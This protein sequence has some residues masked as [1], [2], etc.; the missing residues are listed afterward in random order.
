MRI[1]S[2]L[3]ELTPGCSGKA[4]LL[5]DSVED[6]WHLY[7][8]IGKGDFIKTIT[9]RK[10]A[11]ESGGKSS[12]TKKKINITI[13][14]EEI[15]YDQKEGI[16]RYKGKN[17]SE[18]EFI[19]IG[20]YQS[21]EIAKG[22]TFTVFKKNWD[23]FHIERLKQATDPTVSSDL[24]AIVMEEGVA[25][26]YL[27]SAHLTT[28]Q[29]KIEQ[30]IPK[31]RKGATQHDKSLITFFQKIL[32]A[33]AK[34]INFELVKCVIVAS[35][36][37]TKDQFADYLAN[38]TSNDKYNETIQKNLNK[39]IY[40]H[41]SSGYKQAL[42]EV[43]GKQ[44]VL[45][46]IKNTKATEDVAMMEKFNEIL[47][48]DMDRIV[49]GL[50]SVQNASDK[51]AIE[52]LILTDNFLRKVSPQI[53]QSVTQ[54]MKHVKS[55]GGNVFK[56]SSQHVTG[57]KVDSFGGITAILRYAMPEL[58]D[59]EVTTIEELEEQK[60]HH[61]EDIEEDDKFA[62]NALQQMNL[63]DD[64]M[65]TNL[66]LGNNSGTISSNVNRSNTN[67][68]LGSTVEV[69]HSEDCEDEEAEEEDEDDY[70]DNNKL[71]ANKQ[72]KPKGKP[73]KLEKKERQL[74]RKTQ[75]RKKSNIDEGDI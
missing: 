32:E 73:S 43:L 41:S 29:A 37:F 2:N 28:L 55:K 22:I 72:A 70:L 7:N 50:I 16:I 68:N 1:K 18:N 24:A 49:F 46:Q 27:I 33:I 66:T 56:M 51:D 35:P 15:E 21:I 23:V 40:V 71:A 58:A 9:F 30:N 11:H 59:A 45:S 69:G 57:E 67:N 10:V 65:N 75:I 48:T 6:L 4:V 3:H 53:R 54:I 52:T 31:K 12:S 5:C 42:Q 34:N 13:K 20:Q 74:I 44:E 25:H 60:T 19:A 14:V 63:D 8:L 47:G 61:H 39:F 36:G 62:M 17:V 26:L 38:N 64:S